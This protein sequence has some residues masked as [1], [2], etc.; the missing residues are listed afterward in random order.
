MTHFTGKAG[1]ILLLTGLAA[2][3]L[4]VTSAAAELPVG[5]GTVTGS[6]VRMRSGASTS[7]SIL[8][9][10]DKGETVIVLGKANDDWYRI[11]YG[12][13]T[14]CV[15]AD[16][17]SADTDGEFVA[18]GLTNTTGVNIRTAPTTDSKVVTR[19]PKVT[20]LTV[21]GVTD[22]WYSVKCRYGTTGYIRGDLVDLNAEAEYAATQGDPYVFHIE[23]SAMAEKLV[24]EARSHLGKK[25]VY[26]GSGPKTFDCSGFTRYVAKEILDLSLPHSAT[27][28]WQSGKGTKVKSID[29][30]QPGDFVYF[31]DPSRSKGKACSHCGVYIGNGEF[32]H[33]SSSKGKVVTSQ[34]LSGYYN[35]YFVG[36]LRMA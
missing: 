30:L 7:T 19:L 12:G 23:A 1:R 36:G 5:V 8:T 3:V 26:G 20:A 16:Y 32:I 21:T 33:A 18:Y 4:A 15:S 22:G 27:S 35:N 11:S 17:L 9:V 2:V 24:T 6:S 25:Y 34:L 29:Q 28:Q 10:L 13:M 31:C 14:G